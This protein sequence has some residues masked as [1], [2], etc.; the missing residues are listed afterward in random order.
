[1]NVLHWGK[2][3]KT[4]VVL[5]SGIMCFMLSPVAAFAA[6]SVTFDKQYTDAAQGTGSAGG[7]WIWDGGTGLTLDNYDGAAFEADGDINLNLVGGN[8]IGTSADDEFAILVN[9]GDTEEG[10]LTITGE[11][12]ASLTIDSVP[13]EEGALQAGIYA[14]NDITIDGT[15]V[16][17][18]VDSSE[19][20]W[21]SGI[22]SNGDLAI[23]NATVNSSAKGSNASG[24]LSWGNTTIS[25]S[26]VNAVGIGTNDTLG[27]GITV[28]SADT[29]EMLS[30]SAV[31]DNVTIDS[32][33]T[34]NIDNSNVYAQGSSFAMAVGG[35]TQG[36]QSAINITNSAITV[37]EGAAVQDFQ[38][39]WPGIIGKLYGKTIGTG[40]GTITSVA[41]PN[42]VKAVTI[43]TGAKPPTSAPAEI[44]QADSGTAQ[45][46][47]TTT[48][49]LSASVESSIPQTGDSSLALILCGSFLL[50]GIGGVVFAR[51]KAR[52]N[53]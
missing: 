44:S 9:E 42:L 43:S 6:D 2:L 40:S 19:E 21:V 46:T 4:A 5:L 22:E 37:P 18:K 3:S 50:V 41:D 36:N 51:R 39:S 14:D 35:N 48:Q 25:N 29:S 52:F 11:P 12:E 38:V 17:V 13:A 28:I 20:L 16:D 45:A 31:V 47:S 7:K 15:K 49:P 33:R 24:L 32:S 23:N 30:V 10:N 27:S 26:T 34:L 1:M 53:S 8:H